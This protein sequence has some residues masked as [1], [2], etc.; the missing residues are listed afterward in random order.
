MRSL[1]GV[2]EPGG[3]PYLA[4][5]DGPPLV[6]LPGLDAD[7]ARLTG[8][9]GWWQRRIF[10]RH[11]GSFTVYIVGRR[12][13]LEPRTTISDLAGHYAMALRSEFAG[14][15]AIQGISTGGSIAQ[16]LAIDHPDVVDRLVLADT[17][18][19]LSPRGRQA[20][21]TM[22]RELQAGRP[23][24]AYAATGAM[25]GASRIGA[26]AMA[27][28]MWILGPLMASADPAG[29]L[30]TIAAEDSFDCT[31]DL[32]RIGAPTLMVV[33]ERDAF[34]GLDL[35][36]ETAGGIPGA[37]LYVVP[38][39]GHGAGMTDRSAVREVLAFLTADRYG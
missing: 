20:Q 9:A 32:P 22:A 37:R 21:Q 25:L 17:A 12:P 5:G 15:V 13:W 10:R 28:V 14:P 23:R 26:R 18:C 36:R 31:A 3:M 27:S 6:A 33:G 35:F 8:S 38:R 30:V 16:R 24:Q 11:A 34:Y 4:F 1:T 39:K 19:R 7:G 29:L 2:L